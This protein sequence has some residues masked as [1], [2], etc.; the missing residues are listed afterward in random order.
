MKKFLILL[1]VAT[2]LLRWTTPGKAAENKKLA[3]TGFG[4]LSVIS[5]AR[6]AGMAGAVNSL[7]MG[8]GGLFFNPAGLANMKNHVDVTASDNTWIAD[9]HHNTFSMAI[10]PA[11]NSGN[12]WG[13][14]GISFQT[15][16]Y[17]DVEWTIVDQNNPDGSGYRDMGLITPKAMAFGVGYAKA[18]STQFS[19]G[20]QVR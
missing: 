16:N 5:D 14:I 6:A 13:V 8:S 15:V 10:N 17:G 1:S 4:F 3:Q 7:E 11:P 20:G 2:L 9:I 19:V 18:L 12:A